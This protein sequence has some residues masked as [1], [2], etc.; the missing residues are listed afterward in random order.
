MG[1]P[2]GILILAAA[3][4]IGPLARPE[5]LQW[6]GVAVGV[7]SGAPCGVQGTVGRA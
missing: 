5:V 6:R 1:I 3:L 2:I 7:W 4:E